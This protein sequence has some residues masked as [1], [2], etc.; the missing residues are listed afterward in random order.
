VSLAVSIR[1]AKPAAKPY[2]IGCS[3]GLFL[4]INP[5]GSKLWRF[6]YRF[7]GREK[8]LTFGAYPL[9]ALLDARMKRDAA[10]LPHY[11]GIRIH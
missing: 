10:A 3:H 2:K 9:V 6:K 8:A 1:T 11:R 5:S 7:D 4:L